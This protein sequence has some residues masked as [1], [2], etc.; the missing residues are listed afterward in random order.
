MIMR[1]ALKKYFFLGF[2]LSLL[3]VFFSFSVC[4]SAEAESKAIVLRIASVS[5]PAHLHNI[6]LRKWAEKVE[7]ET[8]GRLILKV[9]D[10]AQLGGERDYIE[11]MQLGS[12]EL[13]Q[14]S[15][16]PISG[17]IPQFMVCSLPYVFQSYEQMKEVT[18]GPVGKKLFELLESKNIKG[19]AWFTNGFRSVFNSVRPI[20]KPSDLKGLK[21]RVMESPLMVGTLNAM[22]AS[23]TPMAY[24]E[25]YTAL[26]QGVMD[27]AE[28][29][30]GNMLND[31]FYEVS[32]YYSLTEHFAP[33]GVVAISM[34]V[35]NK[36]PKD[37]QDYLVE[38]A[39]WLGEYEMDEDKKTQLKAVEEL[40]NKGVQVN[41][42]DKELF[43]KAVKPVIDKFSEQ[44]GQDIIDL[45]LK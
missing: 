10:S 5:G 19:L 1:I 22:G 9:L 35:Y 34:H 11:G 2:L 18:G 27:G 40:K 17:F 6:V 4:I 26:Q 39:K 21:I 13:A 15:T 16:G 28:N 8:N 33:P 14:I 12:I 24:G 31:K 23:A 44:I 36:L 32:K 30:P 7:E 25:L 38:S 41:K 42:V 3:I 20:Y 45:V 29:A 37:L 43:T